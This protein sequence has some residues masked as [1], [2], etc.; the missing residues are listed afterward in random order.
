MYKNDQ[1]VKLA[2]DGTE[3]VKAFQYLSRINTLNVANK[4]QC[5]NYLIGAKLTNSEDIVF[6]PQKKHNLKSICSKNVL[7]YCLH[8]LIDTIPLMRSKVCNLPVFIYIYIYINTG[9][10]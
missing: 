9:I 1:T 7:M 10:Q 3:C 6:L 4:L 8:F 2:Q 5:Y